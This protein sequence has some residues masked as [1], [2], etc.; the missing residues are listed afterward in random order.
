M[1]YNPDGS[2]T[3]YIQADS[4]GKDKESNWL[5]VGT[6]PFYLVLRAYAP[7]EA[8]MLAL[9]DFKTFEPVPVVVAK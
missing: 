5:P 1:K 7:S 6:G 2:L 3:L 4:P 8:V 9:R